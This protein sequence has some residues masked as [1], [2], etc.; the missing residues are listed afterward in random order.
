M[1]LSRQN[2]LSN[3]LL[4]ALSVHLI[5]ITLFALTIT[6]KYK[7]KEFITLDWVKLPA[8]HVQ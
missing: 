7:E 6:T 1:A 2:R 8:L 5:L 4:I 3:S